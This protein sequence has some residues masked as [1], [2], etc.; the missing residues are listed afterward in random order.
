MEAFRLTFVWFGTLGLCTVGAVMSWRMFMRLE[1]IDGPG[2]DVRLPQWLRKPA[3]T[4]A[5]HD[6]ASSS[7]AAGEGRSCVF[8]SYRSYSRLY[9]GVSCRSMGG[10]SASSVN[11]GLSFFLAHDSLRLAC[12]PC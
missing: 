7:L 4:T 2:Q 5:P 9:H 8:S 11:S 10:T 6:Q 12:C 3:G 1:A